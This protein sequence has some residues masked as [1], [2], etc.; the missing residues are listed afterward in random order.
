M[1][2]DAHLDLAF[3]AVAMGGDLSLPLAELRATPYG[4]AAT[5]RGETPTVALPALRAA[6]VRLAFGTLFVQAATEAFDLSGPT[7]RTPE[8]AH[9]QGQ[10]QLAYYHRLAA[11]GQIT[12]VTGRTSLQRVLNGDAPA[13]GIVLLMEGADPLRDPDEL[14]H[15]AAA[16]LRIVGPA[17][18]ATRYSGGTGAP[19]PLTPLG[20]ALM[21]RLRRFG[22][23]LDVSHLAE[24]SFWQ[25]LELFDGPVLASHANCRALVPGDR[26]LSDAMIRAVIERD[27]VIG[28]VLYNRFL[29]AQWTPN[30]GKRVGLDALVRHIEH[31]CAIAGD[32]R[33]VGIGSDLDGGFGREAIPVG[34][35]SVGDLP[36]IGVALR[37]HGWRDDEIAAVLAGN[38]IRWLRAWLPE[39][40][41]AAGIGGMVDR[42]P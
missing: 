6:D 37:E 10:A 38:W 33:H 18:S 20:R 9:Q 19:G 13:P 12:L 30:Y 24:E 29:D 23:A 14:E 35:D 5:R 21:R 41:T 3:N 39:D 31:I 16:G 2:V 4:Q 11:E 42:A 7:Y 28:V 36:R 25:A 27:G 15:W 40:A 22:L 1:L 17:W 26:Q 32:T 8:E 34:L